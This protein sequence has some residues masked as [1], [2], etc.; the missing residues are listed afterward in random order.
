MPSEPADRSFARCAAAIVRALASVPHRVGDERATVRPIVL[1][2]TSRGLVVTDRVCWAIL[3]VAMVVAAALI[4]YLNRGTTYYFDEVEFLLETPGLGDGNVLDP[5][6]GHLIA[7]TRILYKALLETNGPDYVPFRLLAV[8]TVLLS[9]GLF[10]ALVKRRIGAVPALAPALVLL[11]LGSAWQHVA[12]PIGFTPIFAITAGLAALLALERRDRRGDIA[13]CVLL[14][15][16]VATYTTGLPFVVGAAI[17]VLVRRDRRRRS[18]IFV[19]P[20]ALYAAWWLWS[21]SE[22][23]SAQE[24]TRLANLLLIPAWTVESVSSVL[25]AVSGLSFDFDATVPPVVNPAWGH[26]L[27]VPAVI[28]LL[29]RIRRGK[30]PVALWVSLGIVLTWWALGALAYLELP[31]SETARAPN[32]VRYVYMGA[33]GVLLVAAAAASSIRFSRLGLAV[34]F[35]ACGISIALNAAALRDGSEY[36]RDVSTMTRTEFAMIELARDQVDPSFEAAQVDASSPSSLVDSP[37][38]AYLAVVDRYGSPAPPL[39]ELERQPEDAREYADR[40]L[41][42]ALGLGLEPA[43]SPPTNQGC[44]RARA[45]Q[46]SQSIEVELPP[47]GARLRAE[48]SEPAPLRIGRFADQPT[49][50]VGS[51]PTAGTRVLAIQGDESAQ[52]WE[53]SVT[54]VRSVTVCPLS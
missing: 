28:G 39:A 7:T 35:A 24:G 10:Y 22:P 32:S 26:V 18:W 51:L 16:S 48:A 2:I 14:G 31:L 37:A 6:N 40:V 25:A 38:G 20:L 41:I 33:V 46:A 11:F 44:V 45:P 47:A 42:G 13:A 52:P 19:V 50:Q 43:K 15:L 30:V 23:A 36:F 29:L 54:G 9:T 4:L 5:H 17:S 3:G 12:V 8:G 53:A 21:L 34:L 49:T 1:P 27:A